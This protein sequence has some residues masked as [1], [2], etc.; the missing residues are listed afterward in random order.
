M[1]GGSRMPQLRFTAPVTAI[2][3][4]L[5][6]YITLQLLQAFLT[7]IEGKPD[8]SLVQVLSALTPL[9]VGV[10]YAIAATAHTRADNAEHRTK[11]VEE[12]VKQIVNG[13]PV[14]GIERE[15]EHGESPQGSPGT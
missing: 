8:A 15:A 5:G 1:V 7:H 3:V 12:S 11:R 2:G 4:L 6:V 13:G 14:N 10:L 9:L